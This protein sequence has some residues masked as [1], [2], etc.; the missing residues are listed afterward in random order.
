MDDILQVGAIALGVMLLVKA[1]EK[2]K[3]VGE[4]LPQLTPAPLSEQ[5]DVTRDPEGRWKRMTV[6][7]A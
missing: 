4:P 7:Y 2:S 1:R 5:W 6:S 3:V